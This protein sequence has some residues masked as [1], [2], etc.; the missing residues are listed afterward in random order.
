MWVFVFV[1]NVSE[2]CTTVALLTN[3]NSTSN[4]GCHGSDITIKISTDTLQLNKTL[5]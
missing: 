5:T 2:L 1:F 3:I 4:N